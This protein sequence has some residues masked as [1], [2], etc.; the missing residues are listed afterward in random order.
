MNQKRSFT[1]EKKSVT[2][3]SETL[4]FYLQQH[5]TGQL[6]HKGKGCQRRISAAM[7]DQEKQAYQNTTRSTQNPEDG[8]PGSPQLSLLITEVIEQE[9]GPLVQFDD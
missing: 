3:N 7:L 6:F 4:H 2:P 5:K 8:L 9:V 1:S